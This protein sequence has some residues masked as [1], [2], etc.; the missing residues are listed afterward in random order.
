MDG[1]IR[2][3]KSFSERI[4]TIYLPDRKR[5]M[6]PTCLADCLCSLIENLCRFAITCD[7]TVCKNEIT[8]IRYK[9]TLI[10]VEGIFVMKKKICK[11]IIHIT[12]FYTMLDNCQENTNL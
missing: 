9:N 1:C 8:N 6:L 2:F 10:K 12:Q 11:K 4:A 3:M 7:I 5:P